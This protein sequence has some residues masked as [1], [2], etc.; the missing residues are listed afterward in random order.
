MFSATMPNP[1]RQF[2]RQQ[3]EPLD[4]TIGDNDAVPIEQTFY[5]VQAE[6]KLDAR[7]TCS[8]TSSE[9]P[10]FCNTSGCA[11]CMKRCER[12]FRRWRCG[13]LEQR[14]REMLVRLPTAAFVLIATD[15]A[16]RSGHQLPMVIT[17][18]ATDADPM[19]I[20]S[21]TGRAGSRGI[22]L[23]LCTARDAM[24]HAPLPNSELGIALSKLPRTA[25]HAPAW[26]RSSPSRWMGPH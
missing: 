1:I 4:V 5:E 9:S 21:R 3:R 17:D 20:A 23:T 8:A 13:E 6:G 25:N 24:R 18:V 2:S 22:A 11:R 15:V 16:A 7:P 12:T 14:E 10:V 26:S 19:Y